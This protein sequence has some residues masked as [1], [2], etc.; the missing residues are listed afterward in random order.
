MTR[1]LIASALT[2]VVWGAALK[3]D[4]PP[5]WIARPVSSASRV[6]EF[7]L[8]RVNSDAEDAS[9]I[10]YFFGGQGGT[11]QANLDRWLGQM[12]QP[13]GRASKDVAKT[14]AFTANGLPVTLL[15]VGG[16][17]VAELTPGSAERH[18]KPN[19]R[20]LAAVVETREGPY[21]VKATGPA[22]TMARW[23]DSVITFLESLRIE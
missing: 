20:L 7:A 15:D 11:T 1:L 9:L 4:T 22:R 21:F 12:T 10:V 8:A 16:T 13:D 17:Y 18:N 14:S 19:F 3:Y 6:A 2:F 23:H 5:G